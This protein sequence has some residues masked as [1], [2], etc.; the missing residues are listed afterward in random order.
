MIIA[1]AV[2]AVALLPFAVMGDDLAG[3][4]LLGV[5][6]MVTLGGLI[7]STLLNL[8]MLPAVCL[9]LAP[10]APEPVAESIDELDW[11]TKPME[12]AV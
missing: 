6:A 4:E 10:V 9:R 5:T 2:L 3:G 12:V 1:A 11:E 7:S 8:F